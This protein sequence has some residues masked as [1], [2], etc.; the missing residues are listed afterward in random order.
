M[1]TLVI[2][3]AVVVC[4][5]PAVWAQVTQPL[6]AIHDSELTRAL[7]SMPASGATPTGSGT[8][9]YQWWP[10]DW[11]YFVMPDSLKEALRSDGTAATVVGDSNI[12]AGV[13]LTN[14]L[15]QYPIVISLASEAIRNDEI[16]QLTN[17]VAAGGF[18]FVGSSAFTR[19][20]NGTALGDF[21]IANQMGVHMVVP[22]LTNW[23]SN[24]TF[25]TITNHLLVS[26]IPSGQGPLT[27]RMPSYADE[28]SWGIASTNPSLDHV[29]LGPHDLWQVSAASS[30][31]VLATGDSY[32]YLVVTPFGKGYFIYDAAFQ[33]LLGHGGFAPGMYA[34]MIFRRAIEWAFQ[35][36]N[37]PLP[38]LSPWPYPYDSAF[39]VR[40]DLENYTN[41][42]LDV[43]ASAQVEYN[44]GAK[45]D[46]YLCTG[47]VR[48]D[49]AGTATQTN[50]IVGLRQ[51][52]TNYGATIGPHNGGLK[53]PNNPALVPGAYEYWH[54]GPDEALD[55]TPPGYASGMAYAS[56]SVS[57]S[58]NDVEGWLKGIT[59]GLRAW[60]GC[61]FNATREES[62]QIEAQL[63]VNIAGDD[64]L[65]PFPHWV[66]STQTTDKRYS[67]LTEPVSD[68]FVG[69]LVAQS[70]E[71]WHPPGVH[72]TNTLRAAVD[73]FYGLG[74]LINIY[75]HEL[76]TGLA[77]DAAPSSGNAILLLQDY[78]GYGLNTN[79]HPRLWSANAVGVYQW[80]L[81]RS[82]AQISVSY[83]TNGSQSILTAKIKGASNTNTAIEVLCPGANFGSLVVSTNGAVAGG[84]SYR[85]SID[86]LNGQ[87]VLKL[88]VGKSV[89]NAVISYNPNAVTI[90]VFYEN[91]DE[92]TAPALPSGWTTSA[93]GAQTAWVTRTSASDTPPNA[94]Y[95]PDPPNVGDSYLV[96]PAIAL[97]G[98]Q[99]Q[100]TFRNN[101]SFE[102]DANGYY[103]GG[104]LEI[105][106]GAGAFTDIL[107]AGGSFVSNGYS[108]TISLLYSN[109]LAGRQAWSGNSG[110][111]ITTLVDL[112][113][114]A[115]GQTIQ[116]RWHCGTD[117]GNGNP[118]TNGWYIDT[119]AITNCA[120]ACCWNTPPVLPVQ[121]NQ[122]VSALTTL[123]VTN[124]ATSSDLP[125]QTLTYTLLAGPTN[126]SISA[127]GVIT[128]TP[129]SAQAP[130]TNTIT[131]RVTDSGSPPLSATNSFTVVVLDVNVAPV[132]PVISSQTVNELTLLTVTNTAFETNIHATS[133]YTLVSPPSGAA[134]DT[135]G[136]IT[137][138]PS[139]TQS[140]S[141][142]TLTTVVT[143]TDPYD[144]VNPHL[145]ATNSF[146]VVVREVNI[147]PVLPV[148]PNR[149]IG[150]LTT[151]S[152]TN[153]ATETDIHATLGYT[154]VSPP[155]G[156]S[157]NS[158]GIIT[159]TPQSASTNTL[160]TVVTNTD[161]YDLVN[162]HLS[163]T[164]S[165][166]VVVSGPQVV[167]ASAVLAAESCL[168]TNNVIDPGETVTV[169]FALQNVGGVNTTNL[170]VT[171]LATNGVTGPSGPQTYGVLVAGGAAV[172]QPFTFAANGSCGSNL[173]A[174]LQLQD[175]V[176]NYGTLTNSFILGQVTVL[177]QNFDSVT[178]PV[179]PSGWTT[180]ASGAQSAWVTT[181]VLAD[182]PPNSAYSTD[183]NNV[184]INALVSPPIFLPL[185]QAQLSF[186]HSY[187]FEID[188]AHATN[189]YDGGVLEIQI[190]TNAFV[191]I[192]NAGGAFLSGA[193]N[194]RI[195]M[196]WSN[197]L[198]GRWAWSGTNGGFVTTT[199][200]MPPAAAGQTNQLRWRA[201]TDNG[202]S[203]GGWWVDTIS[204]VAQTCCVNA[205]PILPGQ[206]SRTIA[207]L[208][209]LTVTN[210][211]T[212]LGTP[213]NPLTYLLVNPPAGAAIN[214]N[215]VITWTPTQTQSPSTNTLTTAAIN[216]GLPSLSVTNS[217]TVVVQ[218]VNVAPVLPV[219]PATQTVNE[220]ALLTVTN[221][222]FETNIH[223]TLGYTLVNP[224]GG[225]AIDGNGLITWTP[226]QTQ[227]PST[228]TITT[229][230]TST[231]LYDLVNPHLSATNSFTVVV[232]EVNV[233][234]V[235]PVIPTQTINE[236]TL[237][238]VTNTAF[239]TNIHATLGY[240][241]VNPPGG[242]AIDGNGVITWTPS[243]AQSP[244]TNA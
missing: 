173:N 145:S 106:I 57:N 132:L 95:V 10:T 162:P 67:F 30:A 98:G 33:P 77:S 80:W 62:Y 174:V 53:N 200:S 136:I 75:S 94:A 196:L 118:D 74:A 134:I 244:S 68:W 231:D 227:S 156:A 113:A 21:A 177:T 213:A 124:T 229:V 189:G 152:V 89:T 111:F 112:P 42:M 38:K 78:L 91:F 47:T 116:L 44:N 147:A 103:D 221:T 110:G 160:T 214:T 187:A 217:F 109:S 100:L 64:K 20:T 223:A 56:A 139:Q 19:S 49:V 63:N 169:L 85:T 190:G 48:Q 40:H 149:M 35:S 72:T 61:Y 87:Q 181:S 159:W 240:A 31:T 137:W 166:K 12:T 241:L 59:N 119:V 167:L 13:L 27:W 3:L 88:L 225:A 141:T 193:Y 183:A 46:Y 129:T 239:E 73:Y 121:S 90:S 69:G 28:I 128:W 22:G 17:Y 207:E 215:G 242:A 140:P 39:M 224:P 226:S 219:I 37:L 197:P 45:G 32:P 93:T 208:A 148:Q 170:V 82:N 175:G 86:P 154:L 107:A 192:T 237:L 66:L 165:F 71:P 133:S 16:A 117:N 84:N 194:A 234:P 123:T 150:V 15:P 180:S 212:S 9:G 5:A 153:T 41:E 155:S 203:G 206:T 52:T 238:T 115:E 2:A 202:N 199:V 105:K 7:A 204:V 157:I 36:A 29:Y 176:A 8:T 201:G 186:R 138:T 79:L 99:A 191:D 161:P 171:L 178:A 142:N 211:A 108:G 216:S 70:L 222:A 26:D 83:T 228:N 144:L 143:N 97:P 198:A 51:A 127:N 24:N 18:L 184:G 43:A 102:S 6:V 232:R 205:L 188:T 81:Q 209:T 158:N 130:G 92:V 50:I 151:L 243:Q 195:S 163:A 146:T 55:L 120:C 135:N 58:F 76:S 104:V 220:L 14:G 179:L 122:T 4:L 185:G 23:T 168:P 218:E 164:N 182:T 210:T 125:P 34:Y 1:K 11:N 126:A 230:V 25:A 60:E 96:S 131:T 101:Y 172:S 233:A 236:L 235:L 54:W 65:T 114:A